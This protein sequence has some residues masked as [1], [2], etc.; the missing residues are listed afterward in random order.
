LDSNGP[1]RTVAATRLCVVVCVGVLLCAAS[2]AMAGTFEIGNLGHALATIVIFLLLLAILGRWAWRPLIRQLQH[3]ESAIANTIAN[4]RKRH[5]EAQELLDHYRA[6]LARAEADAR[7]ILEDGRKEAAVARQELLAEARA[8][9]KAFADKATQDLEEA[10]QAAMRELYETAA[11]LAAD[12]AGRI[13]QKELAG[14]DYRRLVD[15]SLA[16]LQDRAGTLSR[17]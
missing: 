4:A 15:E 8:E 2:P 10:R 12:V 7:K 16:Q 11:D 13:V 6:R 5:H 17:E 3:R 14:E 1:I 9:A